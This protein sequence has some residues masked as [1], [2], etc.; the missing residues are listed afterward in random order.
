MCFIFSN[1][2][3]KVT[4]QPVLYEALLTRVDLGLSVTKPSSI[5]TAPTVDIMSDATDSTT[6]TVLAAV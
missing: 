6:Y 4:Q 3:W 2:S 1:K 5:M